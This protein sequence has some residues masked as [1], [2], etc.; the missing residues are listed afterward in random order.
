MSYLIGYARVSKNDGRQSL[1]RQIDSLI[2]YGVHPKMI[3][4]EQV[5][6]YKVDRPELNACLAVLKE[7]D[8]LVADNLDRVARNA[9]HAVRIIE[10]LANR[11]VNIR[12]F[13]GLVTTVDIN[14]PQG[15][16]MV[17]MAIATA[18]LERD[19]LIEKTRDG[20]KAAR[21][22]GRLGGAP[23]KINSKKLKAAASLY[24]EQKLTVREI[25]EIAGVKSGT[26]YR[27]INPD[28]SF[29]EIAYKKFGNILMDV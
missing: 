7:G 15:K 25:A 18:Q 17:L 11:K 26:I 3:Y 13:H 10:D 21:A 24:R 20:L 29:K 22:R 2:Q 4:S 14:S 12:F 16:Y 1:D 8:T 6:G 28:G 19:L 23:F 27:Y 9:S 5:S